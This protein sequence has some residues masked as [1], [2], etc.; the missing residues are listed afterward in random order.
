[1][2]HFCAL[3]AVCSLTVEIEHSGV[4]AE[5]SEIILLGGN[6]NVGR[7]FIFEKSSEALWIVVKT[8]CQAVRKWTGSICN[9]IISQKIV[10]TST[11]S[12]SLVIPYTSLLR[13]LLYV[14]H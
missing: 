10:I 7:P 9:P 14:F 2:W 8:N 13:S 5:S 12:K 3:S 4:I 11:A 6:A 1:M